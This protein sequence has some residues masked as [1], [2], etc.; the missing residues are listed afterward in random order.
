MG[1]PCMA[2]CW[3]TAT[4]QAL[5]L[6]CCAA[7]P[8]CLPNGARPPSPP[9]HVFLVLLKSSICELDAVLV[10]MPSMFSTTVSMSNASARNVTKCAVLMR[11]RVGSVTC[12]QCQ[13]RDVH[14]Q[15]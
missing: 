7:S 3:C 11:K 5:L 15:R 6:A 9:A 13:R 10:L 2:R 1:R 8:R 14:A 12:G 4:H